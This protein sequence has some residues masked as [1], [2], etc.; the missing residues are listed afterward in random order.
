MDIRLKPEMEAMITEN[1]KRGTYSS[2]EEL[3][4]LAISQ[5]HEREDWL[6]RNRDE[7]ARKIEEGWQSARQ[8][9]LMD[10][11]EGKTAM[12]IHKKAWLNKN[13]KTESTET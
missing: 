7:I 10:A 12:E 13:R 4:E 2:A 11:E 1:L 9:R 8:G 6:A 3:I 5:L